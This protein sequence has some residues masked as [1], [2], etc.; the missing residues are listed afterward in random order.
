MYKRQD[1]LVTTDDIADNNGLIFG[2]KIFFELFGPKFKEVIN[3]FKK[4]G[5]YCIKHTD[6]NIMQ[7]MD[8]LVDS[9]ID[10]IDP[11]DPTANT[12]SYTHLD[13][14]KRQV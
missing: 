6:G 8:F 4:I 13:V 10:C 14:Y 12:V 3:G 7:I 2:P 9:G 1:I 5:Y 11:I